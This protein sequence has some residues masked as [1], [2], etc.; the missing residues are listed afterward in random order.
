MYWKKKKRVVKNEVTDGSK[1]CGY[2]CVVV[3]GMYCEK[4]K[5]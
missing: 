2:M 4:K 3:V 1:E 5:K